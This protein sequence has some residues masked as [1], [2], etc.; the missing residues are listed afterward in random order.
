MITVVLV[1]LLCVPLASVSSH[2]SRML[3]KRECRKKNVLIIPTAKPNYVAAENRWMGKEPR[4]F[5]HLEWVS[6]LNLLP[7]NDERHPN[8]LMS[9]VMTY[10]TLCFEL[11]GL[12]GLFC[13]LNECE[14]FKVKLL[15]YMG[16]AEITNILAYTYQAQS[17]WVYER[18]VLLD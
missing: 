12:H 3:G 4:S 11:L 13:F 15:I 14:A 2:L 16:L 6:S 9:K 1:M 18:H 8:I 10:L 5:S 7:V 17:A